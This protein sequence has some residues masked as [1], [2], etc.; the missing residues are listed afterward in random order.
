MTHA[1]AA[2]EHIKELLAGY[3]LRAL[4][5]EDAEE[6]ERLLLEH[7]PGCPVCRATLDDFQNLMGDLALAAPPVEPPDLMLPRLRRSLAAPPVGRG[8]RVAVWVV[9]AAVVVVAALSGWSF[10]LNGR[11]SMAER[12][13]AALSRMIG[14]LMGEN[15]S[16]MV[17]L[18]T[19]KE[20]A[21]A[22]PP[23]T[24]APVEMGE[25]SVLITYQPGVRHIWFF[26]MGVPQ[27]TLGN[28]YEIW[29]GRSGL[30]VPS[31]RFVPG[32]DGLVE[33]FV[34][35]DLSQY[36]EIAVTEEPESAL[37]ATPSGAVR[38]DAFIYP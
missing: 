29:L 35:A 38:W 16:Q 28:V 27:P 10:L 2:H 31:G 7:V 15:D 6:V 21:P 9:A 33:V 12:R 22:T 24:P 1:D 8:R 32:Q 13:Q 17:R 34:A 20:M 30:F 23:A 36:D 14:T 26:G 11:V 19:G 4:E 5:G 25:P 3:A 37:S 18:H